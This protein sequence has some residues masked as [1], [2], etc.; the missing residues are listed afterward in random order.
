MAF[1]AFHTP[2]MI[3]LIPFQMLEKDV[4]SCSPCFCQ[5]RVR[6]P[7]MDIAR[8]LIRFQAAASRFLMVSHTMRK[9]LSTA[10]PCSAH[11]S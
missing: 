1:I 11:Q 8:F 4:L 10:S 6:P 5:K 7:N 3:C 2:E 9:A